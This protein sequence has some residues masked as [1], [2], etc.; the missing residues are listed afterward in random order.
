M[1]ALLQRLEVQAV[2]GGD[3]NLAV[4]HAALRQLGLYR[5][6]QLGEIAGHRPLVSAAQLDLIAV[7]EANG[8]EPI[9]F[10]LI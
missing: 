7:A 4:D 3:D 10:G 5:G 1:D 9:P 8:P 2:V 6:N